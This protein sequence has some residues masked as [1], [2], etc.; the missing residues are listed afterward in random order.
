MANL[1]IPPNFVGLECHSQK[2]E[3]NWEEVTG[4]YKWRYK[5]YFLHHYVYH[6]YLY[7]IIAKQI[8]TGST[9]DGFHTL[10][11]SGHELAPVARSWISQSS[12]VTDD[13]S[14]EPGE[15]LAS[16]LKH[17]GGELASDMIK[18]EASSQSSDDGTDQED[19][20]KNGFEEASDIIKKEALYQTSD[21][22]MVQE[23]ILH[24]ESYNNNGYEEPLFHKS[25]DTEMSPFDSNEKSANSQVKY[26]NSPNMHNKE[27]GKQLVCMYT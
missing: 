8:A 23:E 27:K 21:D 22:N 12:E 7:I 1:D 2:S 10:K 18:E 6:V 25:D 4:Y 17:N 19:Y 9:S 15:K 5:P 26:K 13:K 20:K 24:F 11:H 3:K 14:L 16:A